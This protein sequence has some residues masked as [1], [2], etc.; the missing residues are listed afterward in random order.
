M[1]SLV[2]ILNSSQQKKLH[3]FNDP[4]SIT[5]P[6]AAEPQSTPSSTVNIS[7][8]ALKRGG[9]VKPKPSQP[10]EGKAVLQS[11][12]KA[13]TGIYYRL[14]IGKELATRATKT[15]NVK[16]QE[17][18]QKQITRLNSEINHISASAK[19]KNISLFCDSSTATKDDRDIIKALKSDWLESAENV[20]RDRYGLTGDGASM[21]VVLDEGHEPYLAAVMFDYDGQGKAID[22]SLHIGV[23]SSVPATL[24]NGG[25]GPYYDDR[26]VTHEMVH[27]IM[28]RSMNFASMPIWFQEG[29][30]EFIHGANERVVGDLA[31]IGGG[32]N[33]A[34]KLQ[35]D[36]GNGTDK[37]WVSDSEHYSAGF[38][39]VRYLHEQI[40]AAGHS[41]GIKDLFT[42]LKN[43]PTETFDQGLQRV[44]N[45]R[46]GVKSFIRDYNHRNN[47]A[48]FI[49]S[50]DVAGDFQKSRQGGDTGG[51]GGANADKG[52]IQ[53][54][55]SVIPDINH[56]TDA[57]LRSYKLTWPTYQKNAIKNIQLNSNNVKPLYYNIFKVDAKAIGTSGVNV[58]KDPNEAIS[59]YNNALSYITKE[60][61]HVGNLKNKLK[62]ATAATPSATT[63]IPV[64]AN[65]SDVGTAKKAAAT[66][67]ASLNQTELP[68]QA[69]FKPDRVLQL[70]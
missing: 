23:E 3:S 67:K 18:I 9:N 41:G 26:T 4:L 39:A 68:A 17:N 46:H 14:L 66:I 70:L 62:A 60:L 43:N 25:E 19:Y 15:K 34:I 37:S 31:Y 10:T 12:E 63:T 45:Y 7:K 22:Q 40:K 53:T 28:G 36:I 49:H 47:G 48:K 8:D 55:E 50:R 64:T 27:A 44:A 35:D 11:A 32:M 21:N 57:P 2:N 20:I 1:V 30:A 65:I 13:L 52:P 59:S 51:I 69:N 42:E 58:L 5:E 29:A 54:A 38:M 6:P 56:P 61:N 16:K 33:G 24:P